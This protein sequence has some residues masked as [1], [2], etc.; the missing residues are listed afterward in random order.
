MY[1]YKAFLQELE[2][3]KTCK[4]TAYS[5]IL[6]CFVPYLQMILN[7][8]IFY[9]KWFTIEYKVI[10][11]I[12]TFIVDTKDARYYYTMLQYDFY[13]ESYQKRLLEYKTNF[14]IGV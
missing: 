5:D 2:D 4:D 9:N 13:G 14:F 6:G 10:A 11:Y 7:D 8:I 3:L 1:N 12:P